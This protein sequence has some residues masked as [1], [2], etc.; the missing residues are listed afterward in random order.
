MPNQSLSCSGLRVTSIV[1]VLAIIDSTGGVDGG[2]LIDCTAPKATKGGCRGGGTKRDAHAG[3][4]V[5]EL[6]CALATAAPCA[7]AIGKT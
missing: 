1:P 2:P 3:D 4:I 5:V 6:P 7:G